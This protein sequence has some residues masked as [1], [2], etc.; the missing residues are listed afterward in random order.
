MKLYF[1]P[2][3]CSL[4][5][6]I[7][8]REAGIDFDSERVDLAAKRTA[9]GRDYLAV[10]PKGC[11][12]ALEFDDGQILTET[13]AIAQYIADLK[14]ETNLAPRPGTLERYRLAEWLNFLSSEIHKSFSLYRRIAH[15]DGGRAYALGLLAKHFDFV[16]SYLRDRDYLV[17]GGFTVAD[18]HLYMEL[19]WA[20]AGADLGLGR[21]PALA[22][23][24]ARIG[25]RPAVARAVREV[26]ALMNSN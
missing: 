26:Q 18:A 11:V 13:V 17:G 4:L 6:H 12:P 7:L 2:G 19:G 5:P 25:A 14:P 15:L 24:E 10:N 20:K 16:Q 1:S 23:F 8:F 9:S 3:A 21:W 22:D